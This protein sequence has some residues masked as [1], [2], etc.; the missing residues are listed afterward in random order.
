MAV[1]EGRDEAASPPLSP[2]R[3]IRLLLA[4]GLLSPEA[5]V[6]AGVEARLRERRNRIFEVV[7]SEG[8]GFFVKQGIGS[9]GVAAVAHEASICRSLDD[10]NETPLDRARLLHH[11]VD[12]GVAIFDLIEPGDSLRGHQMRIGRFPLVWARALGAGLARLHRAPV[13]VAALA[14]RGP[15]DV[16]SF[17]LPSFGMVLSS[18]PATLKLVEI[19]QSSPSLVSGL[20]QMKAEWRDDRLI[21]GDIRWDNCLIESAAS[22]RRKRRL[23]LVDWE[24]AGPGDPAWDLGSALGDYLA[25]WVASIPVAPTLRPDR[26]LPLARVPLRKVQPAIAALWKAYRATSDAAASDI[27]P[28]A[29]RLAGARLVQAAFEQVDSSPQVTG[30]ALTLLQVGANVVEHP[31]HAMRDLM[32]LGES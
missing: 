20:A 21:H 32:G 5:V 15:P 18:G 1:P 12:T 30:A 10:L 17:G 4:R 29:V 27:L 25:V 14:H 31:D 2:Q 19:L 11:D 16:L 3:V 22:G 23:R 13:E 26:A 6:G 28:R 8:Q 9:Q 24:H 7:R